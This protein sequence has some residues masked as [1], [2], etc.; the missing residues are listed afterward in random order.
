[1]RINLDELETAV[2]FRPLPREKAQ[3]LI[4]ET[5]DLRARVAEM[6]KN[7]TRFVLKERDQLRCRAEAAEARMAEMERALDVC[8]AELD[9]ARAAVGEAWFTGGVTLAEAIERKCR[10]LEIDAAKSAAEVERFRRDNEM[11]CENTPWPEC[12]CPGCETARERAEAVLK[13]GS[14]G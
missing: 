4:A 9:A 6:E 11:A 2:M 8:R 10:A 5:R 1:M 7:A 12:D 3:H 13:G 14:D